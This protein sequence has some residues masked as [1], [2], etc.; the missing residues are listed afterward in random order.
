[1]ATIVQLK[2]LYWLVIMAAMVL[3]Y[4]TIILLKFPCGR[5][6]LP[7]QYALLLTT[8]LTYLALVALEGTENSLD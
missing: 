4:Q 3:F 7:M 1:M 5:H 6:V 2:L 8:N